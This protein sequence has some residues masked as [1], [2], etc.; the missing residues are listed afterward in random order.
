MQVQVLQRGDSLQKARLV[1]GLNLFLFALTHF[2]NHA[3]G[4]VHIE[5]MHEVQRLRWVVTRS[6]PGSL[7]LAGALIT[8]ISLALYK[9]ATRTTLRMQPWEVV[10]IVLG[11]L[12]PFLLFPHIVNTRVAHMFY[13]VEDNYIYELVRLWPVSAIV[14]STLLIMVWV[15]GCLGIHFWLRLYTPYRALQPVLL[16]FLLALFCCT[17]YATL[18][19]Y[20]HPTKM[21]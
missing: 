8:H 1:S 19:S 6:L 17:C 9:V 12:I 10:Q 11:L 5:T 21:Q 14:Q 18:A 2:L 7:I 15:H 16:F 4:L 13:G 20:F 3:V